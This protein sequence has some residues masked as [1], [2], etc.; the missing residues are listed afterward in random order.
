MPSEQLQSDNIYRLI[1]ADAD[2][3]RKIGDV[4][5]EASRSPET[6]KKLPAALK[7]FGELVGVQR[8]DMK[9]NIFRINVR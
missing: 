4:P 6:W 2:T 1:I 5:I 3:G 8:E 7:D 9:N